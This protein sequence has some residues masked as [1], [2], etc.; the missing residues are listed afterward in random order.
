M[1]FKTKMVFSHDSDESALISKFPKTV[2]NI[3]NQLIE[4]RAEF[5][6]RYRVMPHLLE[7]DEPEVYNEWVI[8]AKSINEPP[9][10]YDERF[11]SYEFQCWLFDYCF[12]KI[13]GEL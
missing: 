10:F 13:G 8:H 2:T 3:V 9:Y 6:K 1:S 12:A 11:E 7:H 5:Y 4:E